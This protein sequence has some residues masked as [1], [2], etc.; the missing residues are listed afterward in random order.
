MVWDID[1]PLLLLISSPSIEFMFNRSRRRLAYWF[2]L[3]MGSILTVFAFVIYYREV[4]DQL[5]DFDQALYTKAKSLA[6]EAQYS[7]ESQPFESQPFEPRQS[8][9]LETVAPTDEQMLSLNE[10]VFIRWY[11]ARRHLVQFMGASAPN[12]LS[13]KAGFKTVQ[14][15]EATT[16]RWLRELTLELRQD[17]Q[18]IGYLQVATALTPVQ[19]NL[20][21]T[22]L[23]LSLG[24]P[25]TLGLIG[26]T[27]W[28][29][30]TLA[31]QPI[32]RAYEQLQRFT[33]DASHELRAPLAA[34][35]SNAQ[36][37]LLAPVDDLTQRQQ[38][39]ENIV[40]TAKLMSSLLNN[41]LLLARYEGQLA[42]ETLEQIDLVNLLQPLVAEYKA[43]AAEQSLD[44]SSDL[45]A[46]PVPFQ[47]DPELLQQAVRNLLS[48]ACRYTPAAGAV[49][50]RLLPQPRQ[51]VIAIEDSG[52]GIPEVNL[53]HIFER[54]YRVDTVRSR[55]TGGFG[56]GLAI[57][58]QI[59]RA[60]GGQISVHSTVGKGSVFQIELPYK[61]KGY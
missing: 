50:L 20:E 59:V 10:A 24:V 38:R 46:Q 40:E 23:F 55:Q 7:F 11:D 31:M 49:S 30:G 47:A 19:A 52:I 48:N 35:M 14:L 61:Q 41:L 58:Q 36:V 29:L 37:G 33:A 25:V 4:Q 5:Q 45:P 57:A 21:R 17:Q 2:T 53:P 26:L 1:W 60:H 27:G 39:L 42:P 54:F 32:R 56:L 18:L 44:F 51:V 3:S 8:R 28:G 15:K 34:V 12:R 9:L 22:R 13:D 6:A 43:I 16:T